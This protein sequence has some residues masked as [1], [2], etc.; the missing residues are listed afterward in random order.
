MQFGVFLKA[1]EL[2]ACWEN[3]WWLGHGG[4]NPQKG[5]V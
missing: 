1:H 2:A 4:D 3:G 5:S